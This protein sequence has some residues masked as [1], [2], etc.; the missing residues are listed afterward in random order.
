MAA[1][2]SVD[3]IHTAYG[4][5]KVLFGITVDVNQGECVCLLGRNGVGKS[6]TIRSIMG[7]NPPAQGRISFKGQ[8]IT[9]WSPH[10]I[11]RAGLGF[12]PE[13]RRIFAEL[14][15]WENLDIAARASGRAGHWTIERIYDVFPKLGEIRDRMG[16]FLS[17]GEQQMLT[18]AR[19]LMTNPELLLLDEPSEGLAPLVVD[20][21]LE[22]IGELKQGGL[23]ILLAEQ[24]LEFS[25]A[26]ADRVYVLEKGEV[27]YTGPASAL[28]DDRELADRLLAL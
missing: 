4:L 22:K 20:M 27:R 19:T 26:L 3:A 12:V 9:G 8:D 24:G 7:F 10:R 15:V 16:G 5:S 13:D 11:A 25:L 21:L 23:T 6:T 17:G 14:T 1:L 2:L 18:I 28:R